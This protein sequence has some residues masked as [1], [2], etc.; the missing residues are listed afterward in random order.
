MY[1]NTKK[2]KTV[3]EKVE[4]TVLLFFY[5]FLGFGGTYF[6]TNTKHQQENIGIQISVLNTNK[7]DFVNEQRKII[8]KTWMDL[9]NT[10]EKMLRNQ[11][12]LNLQAQ[13]KS[14]AEFIK[15]DERRFIKDKKYKEYVIKL[16][17]SEQ[18]TYNNEGD[19][20]V[21][22]NK[23][24]LEMDTSSDCGVPTINGEP[25]LLIP[26]REVSFNDIVCWQAETIYLLNKI[27]LIDNNTYD[28]Y[29]NK[30]TKLLLD[31]NIYKID[32]YLNNI[33]TFRS[34][35][36]IYIQNNYPL[37]FEK[38]RNLHIIMHSDFQKAEETLSEIAFQGKS[39]STTKLEWNFHAAPRTEI[40][41]YYTIPDS[42]LGFDDEY[43]K[44]PGGFPNPDFFKLT[45]IAGAQIYDYNQEYKTLVID[46]LNKSLE[47]KTELAI[48]FTEQTIKQLEKLKKQNNVNFWFVI[49]LI[50]SALF[51]ITYSYQNIPAGFKTFN[52]RRSYEKK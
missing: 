44:L 40:L 36:L 31:K 6:I 20:I 23:T 39:N 37:V 51:V 35:Q 19:W 41:E 27:N 47:E 52:G 21:S 4:T 50:F 26:K 11:M 29:I 33:K 13:A 42:I 25:I 18:K 30:K 22:N 32:P 10:N 8:N 49:I 34:K 45:L 24:L 2:E 12:R 38:M 16:F 28:E 43:K 17:T 5:V 3:K 1:S 14:I 7:K 48:K 15:N 46:D 9:K